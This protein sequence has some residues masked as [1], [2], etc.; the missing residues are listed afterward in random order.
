[1]ATKSQH[2]DN[3]LLAGEKKMQIITNETLLLQK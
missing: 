1:M 3:Q 2:S